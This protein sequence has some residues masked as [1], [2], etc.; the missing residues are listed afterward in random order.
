MKNVGRRTNRCSRKWEFIL[1]I[2]V[3]TAALCQDMPAET[4]T[5]NTGNFEVNAEFVGITEDKVILRKSTG[6]TVAVPLNRLSAASRTLA[7]QLNEASQNRTSII[8]EKQVTQATGSTSAQMVKGRDVGVMVH[9]LTKGQAPSEGAQAV[10]LPKGMTSVTVDLTFANLTDEVTRVRATSIKLVDSFG[11]AAPSLNKLAADSPANRQKLMELS[12]KAYMT[13][14]QRLAPKQNGAA[15]PSQP[16]ARRPYDEDEEDLLLHA[17]KLDSKSTVRRKLTFYIPTESCDGALFIDVPT[18][19]KGTELDEQIQNMKQMRSKIE[20]SVADMEKMKRDMDKMKAE[21]LGGALA[22]PKPNGVAATVAN[23]SIR[24]LVQGSETGS[25]SFAHLGDLVQ[26]EQLAY[27]VTGVNKVEKLPI[28]GRKAANEARILAITYSLENLTNKT[29]EARPWLQ[30]RHRGAGLIFDPIKSILLDSATQ[31]IPRVPQELTAYFSVPSSLQSGPFHLVIN[32]GQTRR[33]SGLGTATATQTYVGAAEIVLR[34]NA[35]GPEKVISLVAATHANPTT[36]GGD[37]VWAAPTS[38]NPPSSAWDVNSPVRLLKERFRFGSYAYTFNEIETTEVVRGTY[39]DKACPEGTKFVIVSGT[40]ENL[41]TRSE[42]YGLSL[43]KF[44]L[45]S[46]D[47]AEFK[48]GADF[49]NEDDFQ[50]GLQELHPNVPIRKRMPFIVPQ[51]FKDRPLMLR[52]TDNAWSSK[53]RGF[54][55]NLATEF[56]GEPAPTKPQ[57]PETPKRGV[58]SVSASEALD[59][60]I[61]L[62]ESFVLT[63]CKYTIAKPTPSVSLTPNYG[64]TVEPPDNASFLVVAY[65]ATN[66]TKEK[67]RPDPELELVDYQ[68]RAFLPSS[69]TGFNLPRTLASGET[70]SMQAVFVV[71]NDVLKKP[72]VLNLKD[73]ELKFSTGAEATANPEFRIRIQ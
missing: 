46:T 24:V 58:D 40:I 31:L 55:V 1:L 47:G 5:D 51:Q 32:N 48:V 69:Y 59:D 62:D 67:Y 33:L 42:V 9:G 25:S 35:G 45:V 7:L 21:G 56:N 13:A 27:K 2:C 38:G 44:S 12:A 61:A 73:N 8:S 22:F 53:P 43:R 71:P 72:M 37:P 41:G 39:R 17:I 52:F 57:S 50:P 30:L 64:G 18:W 19:G 54:E 70:R 3:L 10:P 16:T 66:Q 68:A 49:L 15:R 11:R 26:T 6:K 28:S 14:M 23:E 4:W 65:K 63:G 20:R 34:T 29:F 60:E 36:G